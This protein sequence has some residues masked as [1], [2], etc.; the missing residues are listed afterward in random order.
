MNYDANGNANDPP[1]WRRHDYEGGNI[2]ASSDGAS[3]SFRLDAAD[4]EFGRTEMAVNGNGNYGG[5]E[6]DSYAGEYGN[7]SASGDA[8]F[9]N[10]IE[11]ANNAA[12]ININPVEEESQ[13][14]PV[15]LDHLS[16]DELCRM[17]YRLDYE[18]NTLRD[19]LEF[20]RRNQI[21]MMNLKIVT[22]VE[23]GNRRKAE[24]SQS[25]GGLTQAQRDFHY[26]SQDSG[27]QQLETAQERKNVNRKSSNTNTAKEAK[28]RKMEESQ[29]PCGS[30]VTQAQKTFMFHSQHGGNGQNLEV[31]QTPS[32]PID[33]IPSP[34]EIEKLRKRLGQNLTAVIKKS[35]VHGLRKIP[36]STVTEGDVTPATASALMQNFRDKITSDTKRMIKWHIASD[37]DISTLLHIERLIHPV[38]RDGFGRVVLVGAPPSR[39]YH[40]AKFVGLEVRYDKRD[41]AL[42]AVAKTVDAGSGRPENVPER[43]R[44]SRGETDD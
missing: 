30:A 24:K 28:K 39:A 6:G 14:V 33:A 7:A 34:L 36:K 22:D 38:R 29:S 32:D 35:A 18:R 23:K 10:S 3:P 19:K 15:S 31:R 43:A 8:Y 17:I 37:R 41:M 1:S 20:M 12:A 44:Y 26:N 2:Y 27:S 16:R 4:D 40:W 9:D 25:P 13:V 21:H 11:N 42:T 5:A